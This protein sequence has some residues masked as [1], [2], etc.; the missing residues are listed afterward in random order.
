MYRIKVSIIIFFISFLTFSQTQKEIEFYK[1]KFFIYPTIGTDSA[2]YYTNKVFYSKRPIDLAFA[3]AAKWQLLFV[4]NQKYNE[5]EFTD[6]IDFYVKKVPVKKEFLFELANIYN[7]KSHTYRL[8]GDNSKCYENLIIAQ[9]YA[10]KNGDFKQNIKIKSNLSSIK[11]ALGMH[12]K[13]IHEIKNLIKL[14]DKNNVNNDDY[15]TDWKN[16]NTINLSTFYIDKYNETQSK[17]YLD[18]ASV[19]LNKMQN[20]EIS[21]SYL[22]L[23]YAKLGII[24]NELKKY[25]LA[26]QYY[27][28]SIKI[29]S[30]LNFYSEIEVNTFNLGLNLYQNKKYLEAKKNFKAII[31]NKKDTI[32]NTNYLF[33]HKYL[34]NIY[35]LERNDSATYYI[36]RFT[37]LYSKQTDL[38]R[39]ALAKTYSKI[40]NKD[41]NEEFES[42]KKRNSKSQFVYIIVILIL[43]FSTFIS[44]IIY[45]KNKKNAESKYQQLLIDVNEK[46]IV[47][48][49]KIV[50]PIKVNNDNEKKIIEGLLK[51]ENDRFFLRS[52]FN[53]HTAAK[54]IGSNTT[55]LTSVIK[56]YKKMSFN[57][58]TNDLR[59]NYILNELIENK[60]LQNYTIQSLAEVVG[61]KNGAS[62][63]K[64]FKQKTGL[65]PF[66]FIEKLKKTEKS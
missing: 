56:S 33:S 26:N 42:L 61:Y 30:K 58:Y 28:N 7:I 53:L 44:L 60:K 31:T 49:Q 47:N 23:V 8:K 40:E 64:I 63:S 41:L 32:V 43:L 19:Y 13:A 4:T 20:A 59:I 10:E 18:S 29:Y 51:L 11:G 6:K 39:E 36:D 5:K 65:S 48:N 62:F 50:V 3:N 45:Y 57:D 54:K 14:I 52:D 34:A 15:L 22:A 12:D 25:D 38:E 2:M 55:Y 66:Q 37:E 9:K 27:R 21:D 24:N 1:S 35:T 16:R 46:K 17:V